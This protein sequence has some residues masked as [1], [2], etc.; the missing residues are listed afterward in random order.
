MVTRI[1]KENMFTI[2]Q[3][4]RRVLVADDDPVIRRLVSS[5]VESL[6][7]VVVT[8]ND[9]REAFRILQHDADFK[10]AIFDLMMPNLRGLDVI[11][12]MRTEKRLMRI[13]AMMITSE[14]NG[15][16]ISEILTAGA[17]V[18]LPK[19]FTR[20]QLEFTLRMLLSRSPQKVA[21]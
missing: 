12:H 20:A 5:V 4:T 17:A 15:Q 6:D 11:R 18:Y 10:A 19:P 16:I 7:Y 2:T 21:A 8:A 14:T 13:P 1:P 9:G 3:T